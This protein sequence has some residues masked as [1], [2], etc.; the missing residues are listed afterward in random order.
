MKVFITVTLAFCLTAV[1]F[2][3]GDDQREEF[4]FDEWGLEGFVEDQFESQ[5]YTGTFKM[6]EGAYP[7]IL[8][9]DG[10]L[11]YLMLP[12][13]FMRD[14]LP[15]D[16]GAALSIEAFKTH[17]SPMHLMI[18]SAEVNG[19]EVDMERGG[20]G[21]WGGPGRYGYHR[22]GRWGGPGRYGYHR[23]GC[24]GGPDRYYPED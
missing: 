2:A 10:E 1:A 20:Y 23:R 21:Y 24:W 8:T 9:D 11:Y 7:A 5:V 19:E 4:Y 18:V 22:R 3:S 12:D 14:N 13:V 15:P 16:E 6:E 17:F